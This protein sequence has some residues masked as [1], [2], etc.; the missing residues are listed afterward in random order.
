MLRG[1]VG[2]RCA[3]STRSQTTKYACTIAPKRA[4]AGCRPRREVH[5]LQ[6]GCCERRVVVGRDQQ[7]VLRREPARVSKHRAHPQPREPILAQR[8]QPPPRHRHDVP[9]A[10]RLGESRCRKTRWSPAADHGSERQ[11][12]DLVRAGERMN[13]PR[14][15]GVTAAGRRQR[16]LDDQDRARRCLE[17]ARR[18]SRTCCMNRAVENRSLVVDEHVAQPLLFGSARQGAARSSRPPHRRCRTSARLVADD[19][20]LS[21]AARHP[22]DRAGARHFRRR[23]AEMLFAHAVNAV[24]V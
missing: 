24:A 22:H 14:R 18:S 11:C 19:L 20:H 8:R 13:H 6:A 1:G 7:V 3:P 15:Y 16:S 9:A 23:H 2:P 21:A 4:G 12:A 17:V 10:L 5:V